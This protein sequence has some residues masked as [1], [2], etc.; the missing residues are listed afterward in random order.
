MLRV[1]AFVTLLVIAL[2]GDAHAQVRSSPWSHSRWWLAAGL[3]GTKVPPVGQQAIIFS[4]EI[5][6]ALGPAELTYRKSGGRAWG[7]SQRTGTAVL[8]GASGAARFVA[9][10]VALGAGRVSGCNQDGEASP[11]DP[12]P[13]VSGLAF[14]IGVDLFAAGLVGVQ[15]R[16][17]GIG[18]GPDAYRPFTVGI[19]LG[20]LR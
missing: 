2:G 14:G 6:A 9:G 8:L 17:Q 1:I 20:K 11:C 12:V 4:T 16:F 5:G 19:V 13:S 10:H 15:F 7:G 18:N 3:G